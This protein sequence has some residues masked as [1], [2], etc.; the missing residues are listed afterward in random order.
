MTSLT[1]GAARVDFEAAPGDVLLLPGP[2]D[3]FGLTSS[4]SLEGLE[5]IGS[6]PS[7]F[8]PQRAV[9]A[10]ADRSAPS[11]TYSWQRADADQDANWLWSPPDHP[12]VR[13][14]PELAARMKRLAA[15]LSP[16]E[17]ETAVLAH[18]ASSFRYGHGQGRFTDGADAV[19]ALSCGL[20]R[21]SCVD[22]HTY[23]V[24]ALSSVGVRAAYV[25]GVFWPESEIVAHDMHCW[26][27]T[28]GDRQRFWDVSHD[29]MAGREPQ[30]DFLAKPGRRLAF[31]IGR[32]QR[33]AWRDGT[34]EVSHFALPHRLTET[35]ATEVSARLTRLL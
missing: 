6:A 22:I 33:F 25:A 5:E 11:A 19:P 30:P 10:R 26:I 1:A 12:L 3:L 31:S 20:M 13:A 34:I 16:S 7:N 2:V 15:G 35:G 32:G 17:T 8:G 27:A 9:V 23:A 21:G 14:A 24:A 4:L 18:V 28:L 29:I